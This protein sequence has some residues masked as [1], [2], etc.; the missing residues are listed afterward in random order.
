M[1]EFFSARAR[2]FFFFRTFL[3]CAN[4][5]E[6][7][8]NVTS[9]QISSLQRDDVDVSV[10]PVLS[11]IFLRRCFKIQLCMTPL[12]HHLLSGQPSIQRPLFKVPNIRSKG[13]ST[14]IK[15][16]TS[17]QR[18]LFKVPNIQSKGNSTSIKRRTSIQRPLFTVPNIQ[19]KG[20]STSI[21]RQTSIQRPL[22]TVPNIQS[23][24]G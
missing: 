16:R 1:D 2:M 23:K 6:S 12:G 4:F 24:L 17:I 13:N 15:R 7:L 19:S 18:P 14:S 22:F 9:Y 10:Y 20:N 11:T 8:C 21:K 5:C 3:H